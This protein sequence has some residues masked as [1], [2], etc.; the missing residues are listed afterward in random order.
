MRWRRLVTV[1]VVRRDSRVNSGASRRASSE[2]I[3]SV[4]LLMLMLLL[5]CNT[6]NTGTH[7]S[8]SSPILYLGTYLYYAENRE[9]LYDLFPRPAA[10]DV[11]VNY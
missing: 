1:G 4:L 2:T 7:Q 11:K 10:G 5:F 6:R 9:Q 3:V 8:T